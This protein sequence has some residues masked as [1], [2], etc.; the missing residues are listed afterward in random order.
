LS[1]RLARAVLQE[2]VD[3]VAPRLA[4]LPWQVIHNDANDANIVRDDAGRPGLIDFG[5]LCRAPRSCG[6]AVA[7]AY[8]IA[9]QGADGGDPWAP[10]APLIEGYRGV[11]PL[12][13][14]E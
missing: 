11:A 7:C 4:S 12:D 3:Q 2:F 14:A 8:A 1:R 5:D 13:E 9:G 10:A 6:L